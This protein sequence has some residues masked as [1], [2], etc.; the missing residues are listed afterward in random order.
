MDT[1]EQM[2]LFI[3]PTTVALIG[4]SGKTDGDNFNI[5]LNMERFGFEGRIYVINP[6]VSEVH[7]RKAYPD[8]K[9]VPEKIDLAVIANI[10]PL[11]PGLV[12]DCVE[13]GIKAIVIVTQ[14]FADADE[15]GKK[16][17]EEI[18]GIAREGGAR[19]IGPN[20]AGIVNRSRNF[21]TLFVPVE[22]SSEQTSI[23]FVMQTGLFTNGISPSTLAWKVFDIGNACD[24]D[25]ADV[26]EYLEDDPETKLVC[27]HIEGL[28]QGRRLI[29]VAR[30]VA[31][32]KPIL[33]IKTGRSEK[34]ARA[35]ATH[36]GSMVGRYMRR[37]LSKPA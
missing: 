20:T 7:G 26:L 34:G 24:V 15:K 9:S 27:L 21:C 31:K 23:S 17:Q 18:L 30:R 33:A 4:V 29:D 13:A 3:E 10:P 5:L 2:K 6:F 1:V 37:L 16:L 19:I 8:F 25:F 11:V 36:T 32:K 28:K 12:K 14:G 35:V 22:K